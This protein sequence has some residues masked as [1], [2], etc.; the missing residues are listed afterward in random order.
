M[1]VWKQ[2]GRKVEHVNQRGLSTSGAGARDHSRP[3]VR[4]AGVRAPIVA[5]KCVTAME[6]MERRKVDDK[7]GVR[8]RCHRCECLRAEPPGI[9]AAS[10][11]GLV[12]LLTLLAC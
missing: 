12:P 8:R 4:W 10:V 7:M 5:K 6:R 2:N 1:G 11:T 9:T 3:R